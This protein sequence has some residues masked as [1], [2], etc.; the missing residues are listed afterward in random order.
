MNWIKINKVIVLIKIREL[1]FIIAV[2]N[3][4]KK[5]NKEDN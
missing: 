2:L 1:I 5:K 4:Q 3:L